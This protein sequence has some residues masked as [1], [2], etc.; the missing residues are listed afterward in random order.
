MS[1]CSKQPQ[2]L[3]PQKGIGQSRRRPR[4]DPSKSITAAFAVLPPRPS[5]ST[6]T[7]TSR[8]FCSRIAPGA[9]PIGSVRYPRHPKSTTDESFGASR[10]W[11]M[12]AH[13]RPARLGPRRKSTNPSARLRSLRTI[14]WSEP[15]W[16]YDA[17]QAPP[18][19]TDCLNASGIP[20]RFTSSPK[21]CS[22]ACYSFF[23]KRL[24]RATCQHRFPHRSGPLKTSPKQPEL[25]GPLPPRPNKGPSRNNRP[26]LPSAAA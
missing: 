3:R 5:G 4:P 6:F 14:L 16:R 10:F 12:A 13:S 24:W 8:T 9:D 22:S 21:G 23:H 19:V 26:I 17:A 25:E 2:R 18:K 15:T 11:C 1:L 20:L 7:S